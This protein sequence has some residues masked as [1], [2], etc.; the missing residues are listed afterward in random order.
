MKYNFDEIIDRDNTASVKFDLREKI[1][2]KDDVMPVWVADM[3]FKTPDFIIDALKKRLEHPILGYSFRPDA[4]YQSIINWVKRRHSWEI[5]KDWISFSPG[6]VPAINMAIMAYTQP[7]DKIIVQPPVYH[8]FFSAIK[9]NERTQ[10]ENPLVLKN[11]RYHINFEDLKTK[12][13]DAKMILLSNPH[14]PGGSVWTKDE[15]RQLGKMCVENDV[16]IMADEIHADLVFKPHKFI[17]VASISPEIEKNTVTFIAPSKTF[18]IAGLATSSVIASNIELKEKYDA[19]LDTIHIGMGNIFGT[20]ASEAAY[21]HGDEWLGQLLEYLSQNIEFVGD[22]ISK[23]IPEIKMIKP[24]G[25]YLIWL[26]CSALNLNG[27]DL[28]D[29]MINDA[30]LGMNDGRMFGTGGDQFMRMNIAC[31]RKIIEKALNNLEKAVNQ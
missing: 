28:K 17:P 12:L 18:N 23:N 24:E 31:P 7:G 11:G 3:D 6:I 8:P 15:L 30:S 9:N 29:F 1:F 22:Y 21:N 20:I 2:G 13:K 10:V 25:T 19:V 26:D 16:L 14:N 27:K 4:Y 5:D